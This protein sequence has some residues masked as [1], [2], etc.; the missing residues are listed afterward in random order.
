MHKVYT[1]RR[2]DSTA[3]SVVSALAK[4]TRKLTQVNPRFSRLAFEFDRPLA[5]TCVDFGKKKIIRKRKKFLFLMLALVLYCV[6]PVHTY[7]FLCLR[8]LC[9]C[10]RLTYEPALKDQHYKKKRL[11]MLNR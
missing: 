7:F 11:D 6:A 10:W 1:G 8:F 9:L 5:S 3:V 2:S 4:R